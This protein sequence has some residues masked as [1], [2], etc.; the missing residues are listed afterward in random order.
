MKISL[1]FL[2][3]GSRPGIRSIGAL[4]GVSNEADGTCDWKHQL[5]RAT[6]KDLCGRAGLS[7]RLL[8]LIQDQASEN[9]S[10]TGIELFDTRRKQRNEKVLDEKPSVISSLKKCRSIHRGPR[11]AL[12]KNFNIF[13]KFS[14]SYLLGLR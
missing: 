12:D 11:C 3:S 1:F 4:L 13:F 10:T 5:E 8:S 7:L 9:I 14:G 6:R 2:S